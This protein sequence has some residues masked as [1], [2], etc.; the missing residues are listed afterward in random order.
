EE[1]NWALELLGMQVPNGTNVQDDYMEDSVE[2]GAYIREVGQVEA[3]I[4]G[5]D[6]DYNNLISITQ[7]VNL[8]PQSTTNSNY[9]MQTVESVASSSDPYEPIATT[10]RNQTRNN[11]A[12]VALMD[13]NPIARG[14]DEDGVGCSAICKC[15]GYKNIHGRKDSTAETKYELEETEA[16]QIFR[17]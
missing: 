10:D 16:I 2:G 11:L 3:N 14:V 9:K 17:L 13:S 8:L 15:Q 4:E 6:C 5:A 7:S 12:N 1:A